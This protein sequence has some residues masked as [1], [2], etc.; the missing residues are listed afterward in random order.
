MLYKLILRG[1]SRGAP[2]FTHQ[3]KNLR[4]PIWGTLGGRKFIPV[5][6]SDVREMLHKPLLA[7][8]IKGQKL[9]VSIDESTDVEQRCVA[10]FVF[11]IL[12]VE[13]ERIKNA[14]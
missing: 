8:V 6:K 5:V 9:W 11:G 10:C 13:G 2:Q 12:G 14:I 4:T 7:P 3:K 1:T